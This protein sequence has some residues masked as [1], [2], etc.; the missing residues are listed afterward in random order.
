MSRKQRRDTLD[1]HRT[2]NLTITNS[3]LQPTELRRRRVVRGVS[4]SKC[5]ERKKNIKCLSLRNNYLQNIN[6]NFTYILKYKVVVAFYP[7]IIF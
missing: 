5:E 6:Q 7:E 2:S 4:P 1:G 3:A